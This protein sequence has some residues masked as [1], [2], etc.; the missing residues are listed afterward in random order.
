MAKSTVFLA[1]SD[2]SR[3]AIL[4]LL[5]RG[6][7][8]VSE[9]L[10]SFDFSQPALSK[11]LRILREAGLVSQRRDGRLRWYRLEAEKLREVA[12]WISHYEK[13]WNEKLDRLGDVLG[14]ID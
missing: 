9:I 4:D 8:V 5:A 6:E 11:H 1:I 3:R 14:E 12:D 7:M 2:P 13:F 10:K